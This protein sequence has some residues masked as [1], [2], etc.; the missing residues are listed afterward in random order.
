MN[1]INVENYQ[2]LLNEFEDKQISNFSKSFE[3]ELQ[4][5]GLSTTAEV[6]ELRMVE[7]KVQK[8]QTVKLC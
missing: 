3:K 8:R 2:C 4:R 1:S 5:K 7:P 6:Q